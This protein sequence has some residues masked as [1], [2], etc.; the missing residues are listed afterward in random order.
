MTAERSHDR[1]AGGALESAETSWLLTAERDRI[2]SQ[3]NEVVAC[4]LFPAG[5]ALQGALG[6]LDG[7][8]AGARIQ[9]A[10]DELDRAISE[11][12][13]AVFGQ[14]QTEFPG[15]GTAG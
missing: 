4:R 13:S 15:G 5:L 12:R 1:A 9:H 8:C 6:L 3:V 14:R 7:H 11:L 2:A 10:I